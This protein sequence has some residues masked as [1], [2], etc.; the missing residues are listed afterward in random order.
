[1]INTKSIL[2]ILIVSLVIFASLPALAHGGE[3]SMGFWSAINHMLTSP[4]HYLTLIG[5]SLV[6]SLAKLVWRKKQLSSLST[7]DC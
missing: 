3:H 5:F 6:L 1:M 7:N 4:M 2:S